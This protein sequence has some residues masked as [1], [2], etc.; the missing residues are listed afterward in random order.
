MKRELKD[1]FTIDTFAKEIGVHPNTVR[2]MIKNGHLSAFRIGGGKTS[3]YR[4]A[5]SE[6]NRLCLVNLEDIVED[7]VNKKLKEKK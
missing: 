7:L 6:I 2:K 4:I 1:F 5:K 3:A